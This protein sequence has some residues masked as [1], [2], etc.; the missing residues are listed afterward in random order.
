MPR[1][2]ANALG[3][4]LQIKEG[5]AATWASDK[6]CFGEASASALEHIISEEGGATDIGF[7]LNAD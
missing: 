7:S 6:F 2:G 1:L 4:A 3:R 5:A